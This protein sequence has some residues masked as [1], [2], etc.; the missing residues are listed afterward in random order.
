MKHAQKRYW[1][2]TLLATDHTQFIVGDS[3]TVQAKGMAG[4]L[5]V[6]PIEGVSND[7]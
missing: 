4:T 3:R 6:Y 2:Q 5:T 1:Y 7:A